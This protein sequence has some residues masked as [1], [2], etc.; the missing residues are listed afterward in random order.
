MDN[1]DWMI[2]IFCRDE[3]YLVPTRSIFDFL[4]E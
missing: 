1:Q 3:I 4:F 2:A